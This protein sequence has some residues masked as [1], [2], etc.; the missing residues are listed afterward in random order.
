[1]PATVTVSRSRRGAHPSAAAAMGSTRR[2]PL[3][4]LIEAGTYQEL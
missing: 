2:R 3:S 1:M 4:V